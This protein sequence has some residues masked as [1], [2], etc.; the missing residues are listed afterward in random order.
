MDVDKDL[1][2]AIKELE[3]LYSQAKKLKHV[4]NPIAYA[5]YKVWRIEDS[6]YEKKVAKTNEH[7]ECL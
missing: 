3:E 5:L 1:E 4:Y 7:K 2:R 6:Q